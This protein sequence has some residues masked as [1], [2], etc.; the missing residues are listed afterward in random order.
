MYA[1]PVLDRALPPLVG[2]RTADA[3][4]TLGLRTLG[5]LL[6]HFPRRYQS[7]D[8]LSDLSRLRDGEHVTAVARVVS[9]R[10]VHSRNGR[11]HMLKVTIADQGDRTLELTFFAGN[12]RA[13]YGWSNRLKPGTV[14]IFDGKL[15]TFQQRLQ[16]TNPR[17]EPLV[18][19]QDGSTFEGR[20]GR[21][22][23][24]YPANAKIASWSIARAML[25]VLPYLDEQPIPDPL[26]ETLLAERAWPSLASALRSKHDPRDTA[27]LARA[28]DR[29]RFEEAFVLQTALARRREQA[30]VLTATPRPASQL[31][32]L[33]A[34][35][36]VLPFEL[37]TGQQQV[38]AQIA[39]DLA[40]EHPMH[41]LL[42]GEVGSGKT[43]V[44]LRAMLTVADSGGQSALL[45]PTEVLAQQH[46]RSITE[47]LGDLARAGMLPLSAE[48][49]APATRV[50][51]LTGSMGVRAR[52]EALA[53]AASGEAGI[54]IGTHALLQEGVDFDDLGLVVVDEQH[55]FGVEQR[56][57]LRAKSLRTPHLL[58]MTATPI[59]RT[60]AMTVFGDLETSTLREVPAGRQP[61]ATHVVPQS[62]EA[63]ERRAWELVGEQ[64]SAG[65][66]VF[67]VC[68]AIEPP[69][70][71][72]GPDGPDPGDESGDLWGDEP[73][74]LD[75]GDETGAQRPEMVSVVEMV[76]TL[77]QN[78]ALAHARL[79]TLHGRLSA[80]EKDSTMRAFAAGEVDVLVCTTVI[81]VGVDVPNA[82]VMVVMDASRFGISQLHQLRGRVGRGGHPGHCFFMV[83][84]HTP[85]AAGLLL[86]KVAETRDG[87]ALA[88]LDLEHR[89]EGDVLGTAQ[90]GS[91]SSL[92]VLRVTRDEEVIVEA[93]ELANQ[94]VESDPE[95]D[96][97]PDLRRA[98]EILLE[99]EQEVFLERG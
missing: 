70:A 91:M 81:E 96:R 16:L 72:S 33:A 69:T 77:S 79:G 62:R 92:R 66:Q 9:Q 18:A 5:D 22:I 8:N 26:P 82:S 44:A 42:Q 80:D 76:A 46:H 89:R 87:F 88:R 30:R 28:D 55:R 60:V 52:R 47:M 31:G 86:E 48:G 41:R 39:A 93:R 23:P 24:I 59:P 65:R 17:F 19:T 32:L 51:M 64:V 43:V 40:G 7:Y 27:D 49:D 94:V 21:V 36:A 67:V 1:S 35:D 50:V 3:L 10:T 75:L 20:R 57:A 99:P 53:A 25:T 4:A 58:V 34:F 90:S 45:A 29:L 97:H 61:V 56:D 63:W 98:I 84:P 14:A 38:G 85:E 95:L 74:M 13:L 37:T 12:P 83:S 6:Y 15:S 11:H 68:P 54:V 71:G 73:P 78:P 2:K